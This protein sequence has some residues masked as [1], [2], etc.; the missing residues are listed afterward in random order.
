VGKCKID[1]RGAERQK[2]N[3]ILHYGIQVKKQVLF[4]ETPVK[5]VFRF[6]AK[7]TPQKYDIFFNSKLFLLFR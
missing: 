2:E 5:P 4:R 3:S 7:T 6:P 1:S